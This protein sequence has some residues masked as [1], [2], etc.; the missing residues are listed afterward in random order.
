[1]GVL[2]IFEK[3]E[4]PTWHVPNSI[5]EARA[6]EGVNLPHSVEPGPENPLGEYAMRL[7]MRNYLIHGTNDPSGVGR[8]SSSGC[9]RLYP[10][11]IEHLFNL[12]SVGTPVR[13]INQPYKV[14]W[15]KNKVYIEAHQPIPEHASPDDL[16][17]A[18]NT[19]KEIEQLHTVYIDWKKVTELAQERSGIPEIV[20]MPMG[21]ISF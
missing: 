5:R 16:N 8:R 2:S 19:L 10:E 9:I 11:D 17:M 6:L 1:L 12:V 21:P 7:S 13:I 20:G 14:G 18:L 15:R 3:M 4:K